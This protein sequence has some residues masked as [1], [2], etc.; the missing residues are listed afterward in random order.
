[1]YV[2]RLPLAASAKAGIFAEAAIADVG[3]HGVNIAGLHF[4]DIAYCAIGL[5]VD[6]LVPRADN[7]DLVVG[8]CNRSGL[9]RVG[10][11]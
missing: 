6:V 5:K 1:M 9:H 8:E 3:Q 7:H 2:E 10:G 11:P 4:D